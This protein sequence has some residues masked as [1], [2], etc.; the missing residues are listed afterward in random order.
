MLVVLVASALAV[1]PKKSTKFKGTAKGTVTFATTFTGKDPLSFKTSSNAKAL[2][3]FTFK[4]T[5][6][7]FSANE[8]AQVG[9][10]KVN[11]AKFSLS[12]H[13]TKSGPDSTKDSH[14]AYWVV[15][16]SGK[17]TSATKATGS[18]T[19]TQKENGTA[20]HCGPIKMSFTAT[21]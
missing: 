14:T 15:S 12:N 7:D 3:G 16:V 2:D 13:K 6:C 21:G 9:T 19:Y 4:D 20:S 17:F 18:L 5:V 11:G 1:T 10:V 8:Q